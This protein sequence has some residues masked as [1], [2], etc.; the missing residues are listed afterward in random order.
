MNILSVL[1]SPL[2]YILLSLILIA[3]N[4]NTCRNNRIETNVLK[5]SISYY[6]D[7]VNTFQLENGNLQVQNK[8]LILSEKELKK[9]NKD[10][11]DKVKDQDGKV[12]SLNNTIISLEQ[13]LDDLSNYLVQTD[14]DKVEPVKVAKNEY[15]LPY[16]LNYDYGNDNSDKFIGY[17]YIKFKNDS[18]SDFNTVLEKRYTSLNLTFGSKVVNDKFVVFVNSDYPGFNA[19]KISSY[20]IDPNDNKD[21]NKLLIK[22][23]W[24]TGFSIGP[25]IGSTVNGN[26]TVGAGLMYGIYTF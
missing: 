12:T 4:F 14:T 25:Y 11:Y 15:K 24:F 19:S 17:T 21:L 26:V 6:K 13:S 9:E 1:K 20:T 10:L 2:T 18:I 22:K 3:V 7:S 23:H 8:T 16:T 5:Q